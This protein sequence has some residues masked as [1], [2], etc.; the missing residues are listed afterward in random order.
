MYPKGLHAK[1][2]IAGGAAESS[3]G[4]SSWKKTLWNSPWSK[5]SLGAIEEL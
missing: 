1:Q 3:M 4:R 5:G 2:Q